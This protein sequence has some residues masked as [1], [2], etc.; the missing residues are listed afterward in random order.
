MM[1]ARRTP[2]IVSY[3]LL[4]VL[5][6]LWIVPVMTVVMTALRPQVE[7]RR[8]WWDFADAH[9]T[10]SNF[11]HAWRDALSSY[12]VNSFVITIG[13]VV[14]TAALG[15]LAAYAFAWLKFRGKETAFFLLITTMIVPVQLII[16]P[17]LPWFKQLGLDSGSWQPF[18]G[19]ILVHTAFGAGWAVFMLTSF[20]AEV[21]GEIIEAARIDGAGHRQVFTRVM[22]PLALPGIVSFTIIDF[23]FV[24]NDLLLGLT[25][26]GQD[27]QPITVGLANLQSPHLAQD[28][29]VSA[30]TILA[31]VPPLLLFALLNR[32]YVRGL[33]GG[34]GK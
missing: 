10:F 9:F 24:W 27:K 30:G 22:L 25:L 6:V 11:V 33:F 26:L 13:A 17:M 21:P 12:V 15:S 4:T 14:V 32:F 29:I 8:G 18:L 2:V 23:V 19:I 34:Y 3:G 7:I 16:I 31:I 1:Q 28:D 20:F 5:S